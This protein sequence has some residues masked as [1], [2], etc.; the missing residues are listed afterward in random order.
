MHRF[1][2]DVHY[3]PLTTGGGRGA[4]TNLPIAAVGYNTVPAP[5]TP[6]VNPGQYTVRLTV[7]GRTYSQP[8][9]VKQD[10]RV[11]TPA[12]A[13]QQVYTL[14]KAMYY[15][16]ADADAAARQAQ[17]LRDQI[18]RIQPQAS[19]AVAQALADF[20]KKLETLAGTPPASA[21]QGRGGGRGR[22]A[23]GTAPTADT[24]A[25]VSSA[26]SGVMNSLQGA[27]VP[28]TTVQLN[29]IAAARALAAK[30]V[31][32]WTT[33]ETVDLAAL[34]AKLRAAGSETIKKNW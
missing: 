33:L 10:P 9:T 8:I 21:S 29:A 27:D 5:T 28:S 22:G 14:S 31:A 13:M 20:D 25:G 15:G 7:N 18:A 23:G 3:Q 26:L 24:L 6:W 32:Q 11:K 1:T 12:L 17:S 2:W 4:G 34:N 16:A 30:A 19:G